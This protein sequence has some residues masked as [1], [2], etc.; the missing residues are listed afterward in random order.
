MTLAT[1]TAATA[2]G[3]DTKTLFS[4]RAPKLEIGQDYV[5]TAWTGKE[6]TTRAVTFLGAGAAVDDLAEKNPRVKDLTEGQFYFFDA[7]GADG[8]AERVAAFGHDGMLCVGIEQT[9]DDVTAS[10]PTRVTFFSETAPVKATP[11]PKAKKAKAAP[12]VDVESP[13]ALEAAEEASAKVEDSEL[14]E[15]IDAETG[16]TEA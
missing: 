16:A 5:M 9:K 7:L 6:K 2:A 12:A 3:I 11:A 15:V 4:V 8:N 10:I 14:A 1:L 13:A